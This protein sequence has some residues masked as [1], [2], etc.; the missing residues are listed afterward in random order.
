LKFEN[1]SFKAFCEKHGIIHEFSS[2]ITPQQSGVVERKNRFLQ[3]MARTM[4]LE[5]NMASYF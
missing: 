5:T 3:G 2:P 1:E 4:I